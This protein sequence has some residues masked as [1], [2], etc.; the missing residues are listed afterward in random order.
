MVLSHHEYAGQNYKLLIAS[1]LFENVAKFMY[2][3]TTITNQNCI[4]KNLREE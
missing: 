3:G 1:K 4:N 2:L